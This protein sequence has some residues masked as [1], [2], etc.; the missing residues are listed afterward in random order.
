MAEYP[1]YCPILG[2]YPMQDDC[3][4]CPNFNYIERVCQHDDVRQTPVR[5]MEHV[6]VF[7]AEERHR[8]NYLEKRLNEHMDYKKKPMPKIKKLGATPL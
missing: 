3:H 1:L 4:H 2:H 7:T 5:V 8:I 6:L